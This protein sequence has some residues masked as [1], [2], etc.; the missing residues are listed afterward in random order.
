MDRQTALAK[1]EELRPRGGPA[2]VRTQGM[3]RSEGSP[4]SPQ[5]TFG[6]GLTAGAGPEDFRIAVLVQDQELL[7]SAR[8]EA[9]VEAANG[10]ADVEYVGV[11]APFAALPPSSTP[12]VDR[13]RPLVPGCSISTTSANAAGTLGCFV[14]DEHGTYLLSN[15]HVVAD[16]GAAALGLSIVQPGLLDGGS[17]PADVVGQLS[18]AVPVDPTALNVADAAIAVVDADGIEPAIPGIG[19][20]GAAPPDPAIGDRVTKRGRTTDVTTGTVRLTNLNLKFRWPDE[21][22]EFADLVA[23]ETDNSAVEFGAPG[24]S[25]ALIVIATDLAPLALL[26]AGGPVGGKTRVYGTRMS[27]VL[28]ELAVSMV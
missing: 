17:D 20:P 26:V 13:M 4:V 2:G 7:G 21:L 1:L 22:I 23:I 11:P 14:K 18:R 9:V 16:H 6:V 12:L 25:G 3:T 24:D 5:P 19:R 27:D 10:E 8:L 15:S 28:R